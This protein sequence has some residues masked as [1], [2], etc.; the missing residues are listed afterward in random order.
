MLSNENSNVEYV[1]I[2]KGVNITHFDSHALNITHVHTHYKIFYNLSVYTNAILLP[3][4]VILQCHS[5]LPIKI[6]GSK[7]NPYDG[8]YMDIHNKYITTPYMVTYVMY[9]P[10]FSS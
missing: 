2:L 9:V 5:S 10:N 3:Y 6:L 1:G 7:H 4:H 8:F